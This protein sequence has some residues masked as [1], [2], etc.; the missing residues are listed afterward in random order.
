MG[1][2]AEGSEGLVRHHLLPLSPLIDKS[3]V[4]HGV[5]G[6]V[7]GGSGE[8]LREGVFLAAVFFGGL[9]ASRWLSCSIWLDSSSIRSS[10][11]FSMCRTVNITVSISSREGDCISLR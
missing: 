9:S 11:R 8:R 5:F 4:C 2:T 6:L 7:I 3:S 10:K 1:H